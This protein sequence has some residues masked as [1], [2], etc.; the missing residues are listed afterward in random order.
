[1]KRLKTITAN[2]VITTTNANANTT[3]TVT[4]KGHNTYGCYGSFYDKLY[5]I[6]SI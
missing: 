1:M 3:Y 6:I 4:I 5:S 2:T